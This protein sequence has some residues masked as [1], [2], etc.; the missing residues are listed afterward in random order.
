MNKIIL[1]STLIIC[2]LAAKA[3]NMKINRI[4]Y[5]G[6]FAVYAPFAT[7]S[8]NT[9]SKE[10]EYKSLLDTPLSLSNLENAAY[11]DIALLPHSDTESLNLISFSVSNHIYSKADIKVEGL[12][13]YQIYHNGKKLNGNSLELEP[14]AHT[15]AIKYLSGKER[16][17]ISISL[18]TTDA[19]ILSL[20]ESNSR[21]YTIF[22]VMHGTNFTGISLSPNGKFL[23]TSYKTTLSGGKTSAY[24][25]VTEI[26]TGRVLARTS[27]KIAWM[28][29]S[30][31]YYHIKEGVYGK[32]LIVTEPDS[33]TETVLADNLP[34]GDFVI[35]PSEDYLLYTISQRG[36]EERKEIYQVIEPDDRQPGWRN[37]TSLAKYTIATGL[38]QPLTFGYHNVWATDISSDGSKI[39]VF[40]SKSRLTKRPTTL[41]S[42]YILDANTLKATELIKDDGFISSA[43]FSPDASKLLV[44]GSPEAFNGIGKAVKDGQTPNMYDY[45][46][47]V[48]DIAT[49][50]VTPVTKDFNPAIQGYVW[51][52]Y[53]GN[54]YFTAEDKDCI[55]LYKMNPSG[56]KIEKIEAEEELVNR[57]SV[58]ENAP[59]LVYYGQ[60]ASNSDRAYIIDLKREKTNLIEDLSSQRLKG[61]E[62]GECRVWDFVNSKGDT[63]NGRYYLPPHFD[64]SKKY[65]LIVNYYGGCS[66]TSRNFE[67]RYPHH[68]YAALGYVVYVLNPSGATGFGQEFSARH[69]NTAGHGPAEDIIEG[70]KQFCKEH[71]FINAKKIGCIGASYGGFMTQYLQTKT[72]IFAA[73]ISHAGISDHTS[74]W[75]EGYWGYSYSEVSMANSYPWSHKELY[76]NQSP[77]YN[78]D[79]IN[80]PLLFLHGDSDVNVPVGESIQMYTALKLLGKET[81][82]VLVKEQD[83]HIIDYDKR[84][85]WQNTIFAWFAKWLQDSSAWWDAIYSPKDL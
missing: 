8:T 25:K 81:A 15:I 22:D 75:G 50:N 20:N 30:N 76:V 23:I 48:L 45:Q 59:Y 12:K 77:L 1:L 35:A 24:S 39:I 78:A 19:G 4:K 63:I 82:M 29:A 6:P 58:A 69:V 9:E 27:E 51:N 73:A 84:I 33:G 62:L 49:G 61:T 13:E 66:P 65:P 36:P 43:I 42:L 67:S 34:D 40:A 10:F 3:E 5:A 31:R 2:S 26:A 17:E 56:Y 32:Q 46:L 44:S 28:P 83:H 74:Y 18:E 7:D 47:Y 41:F 68:A 80:T 38:M 70:T 71:D 60:S 16:P 52:R 57:F 21:P 72:D 54:I 55:N 11:I 37:R 53:N 14:M 64:A 79:K 85:M